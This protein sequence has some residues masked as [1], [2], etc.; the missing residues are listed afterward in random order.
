MEHRASSTIIPRMHVSHPHGTQ[1]LH[2]PPSAFRHNRC[3]P[4]TRTLSAQALENWTHNSGTD[5][6]ELEWNHVFSGPGQL[7]RLKIGPFNAEGRAD[8]SNMQGRVL[9]RYPGIYPS[10]IITTRLHNRVPIRILSNTT[11]LDTRVPTRVLHITT[12]FGTRVST[13]E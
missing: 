11:R 4:R 7:F 5:Y 8:R 10:A 12:R 13:R 3:I 1:Q 6:L 9:W 2:T